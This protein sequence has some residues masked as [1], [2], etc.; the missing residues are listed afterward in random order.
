M[1]GVDISY[2]RQLHN[3][4]P[5][6]AHIT[7]SVVRVTLNNLTRWYIIIFVILVT[8]LFSPIVTYDSMDICS[9]I[10]LQPG[11]DDKLL[12]TSVA[13]LRLVSHAVVMDAATLSFFISKTD[14]LFQS[15]PSFIQCSSK[16]SRKRVSPP[17]GVTP[18]PPRMVSP[19]AVPPVT[20]LLFT[21]KLIMQLHQ[22]YV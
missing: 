16:S 19:G 15:S 8:Q 20:P 14:H 17:D 6:T 5:A 21:L 1:N 18:P 22:T 7:D 10:T 13:S 9:T 11:E 2:R 12:F 3:R 4:R